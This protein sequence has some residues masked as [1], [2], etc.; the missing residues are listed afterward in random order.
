MTV[1]VPEQAID[2][3]SA[4]QHAAHL[5]LLFFLIVSVARLVGIAAPVPVL[6]VGAVIATRAA[7]IIISA[8]VIVIP[9]CVT[10]RIWP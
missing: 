9:V 7:P 4:P 10:V 5:S 6:A 1:E 3:R 8:P 2:L